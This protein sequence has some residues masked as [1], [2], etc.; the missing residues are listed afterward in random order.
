MTA[1]SNQRT[2]LP[3]NSGVLALPPPPTRTALTVIRLSNA[4]A[5][6]VVPEQVWVMDSG[7]GTHMTP[8]KHLFTSITDSEVTGVVVGNGSTL[9]VLG[10]GTAVIKSEEGVLELGQT[11]FVPHLHLSLISLII[12]DEKGLRSRLPMG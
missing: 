11:L 8:H 2:M 3:Q 9:A 7:A 12:L 5:G 4:M 10:Q 6:M 1:L